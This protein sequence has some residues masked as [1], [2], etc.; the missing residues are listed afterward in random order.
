MR[1]KSTESGMPIVTYIGAACM[2][3]VLVVSAVFTAGYE[4]FSEHVRQSNL[5]YTAQVFTQLEDQLQAQLQTLE[6][7]LKGLAINRTVA[8]F[9]KGKF[10]ELPFD[11]R[12]E[13]DS[14]T[15]DVMLVNPDIRQI[16]VEGYNGITYYAADHNQ[17]LSDAIQKLPE[18]PQFY[19]DLSPGLTIGKEN[20]RCFLLSTSMYDIWNYNSTLQT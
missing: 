16:V 17:V 14:L 5:A 1:R 13:L 2:V 15:M 19:Y 8:A 11:S 12:R 6:D 18:Q 10:Q 20:K 3:L 9:F 4:I 7:S